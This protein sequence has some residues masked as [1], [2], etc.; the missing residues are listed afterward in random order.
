[1]WSSLHGRRRRG[2]PRPGGALTWQSTIILSPGSTS[3]APGRGPALAEAARL[4]PRAGQGGARLRGSWRGLPSP[5]G[6]GLHGRYQRRSHCLRRAAPRRRPL[7]PRCSVPPGLPGSGRV[8]GDRL[9]PAPARRRC[10][11][12]PRRVSS[13]ART[14]LLLAG[15]RGWT[16]PGQPG[17]AS[18][19]GRAHGACAGP[20]TARAREPRLALRC[21][22]AHPG[23]S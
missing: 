12:G 6:P 20:R 10:R 18:T 23:L 16:R 15:R 14:G 11:G 9:G 3:P 7:G 5:P 8:G 22:A 21:R 13:G 17:L 19:V 2:R 1:M 4:G